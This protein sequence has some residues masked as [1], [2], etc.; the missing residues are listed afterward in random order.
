MS[1]VKDFYKL[2]RYNIHSIVNEGRAAENKPAQPQE[3]DQAAAAGVS[4]TD[5]SAET[6]ETEDKP[7]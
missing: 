2:K 3:S 5:V 1:V 4:E 6:T 7:S